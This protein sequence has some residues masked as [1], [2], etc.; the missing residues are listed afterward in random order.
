MSPGEP[1][2][3]MATHR[4]AGNGA[5]DRTPPTGRLTVSQP[6][7]RPERASG[8]GVLHAHAYRY[9]G[10]GGEHQVQQ[11]VD[12]RMVAAGTGDSPLLRVSPDEV[13]PSVRVS[14]AVCTGQQRSGHADA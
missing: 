11:H 2:R 9:L 14:K 13:E 1:H 6:G 7:Q 10:I 8:L 4:T 5:E 12:M 3:W